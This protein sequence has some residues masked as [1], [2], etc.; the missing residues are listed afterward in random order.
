MPGISK[1][2]LLVL[3]AGSVV[4]TPANGVC[5]DET[6]RL[7]R[8]MLSTGGVGYFEHETTVDG[9]AELAIDVRL[10]Q[11]ND[12]LKSIVVYD[13]KGGA[14]AVSL[15]GRKPLEQ[16]FGNLPF[17]REALESPV[18]LLNA[19][20]GEKVKALGQRQL[21]GQLIGV[22]PLTAKLPDGLGTT[23]RYRVSLLT[24]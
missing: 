13:G 5:G 23:T 10:S 15:P 8:V 21:A 19:L 3:V 18:T 14:G 1:I 2:I 9:D 11:V 12:V 17:G 7:R 22:A 16:I 20:K 4:L 6:L 24:N